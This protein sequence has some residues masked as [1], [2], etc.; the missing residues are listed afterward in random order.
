MNATRSGARQPAA[1][2][3]RDPGVAD[4]A[5]YLP[6]SERRGRAEVT[7]TLSRGRL[8][9]EERK[10][11]VGGRKRGG[12]IAGLAGLKAEETGCGEV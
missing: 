12:K 3:D 6:H 11:K 2:T 9:W 8:G 10:G 5:V 1:V 7:R 4:P